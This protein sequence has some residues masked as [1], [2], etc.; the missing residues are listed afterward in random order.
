MKTLKAKGSNVLFSRGR[1]IV[2]TLTKHLCL[3]I[4]Q[5]RVDI[6]KH[7]NHQDAQINLP[8]VKVTRLRVIAQMQTK[9]LCLKIAKGHAVIV[10]NQ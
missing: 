7:Q 10:R 1:A 9:N 8:I 5:K 2:R 4:V 6:V 3:D